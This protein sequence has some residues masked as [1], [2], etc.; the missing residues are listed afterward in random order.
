MIFQI[1]IENR[2]VLV[3]KE[4]YDRLRHFKWRLWE[5]KGKAY[6]VRSGKN[7][8]HI[9]MH[10]EIMGAKPGQVVDHV[11]GYTLDNR[12]CNLRLCTTAENIRNSKLRKDSKTG[13]KGV[14]AKG[15]KFIARISLGT[16]ET[17]EEA[18]AAYNQ[19][20]ALYF[21]E[22]ARLNKL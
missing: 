12:K 13:F 10:R 20:A 15:D 5:S 17:A 2:I 22:F 16:F 18:A 3:D 9:R 7:C 11:D 19:A 6:A 21:G 8:R 1:K 14:S 4:D